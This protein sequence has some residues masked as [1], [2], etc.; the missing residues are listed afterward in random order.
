MDRR[1]GILRLATQNAQP[2]HHDAK[3]MIGAV[4]GSVR[5]G[6]LEKAVAL[7]QEDFLATFSLRNSVEFEEW[8]FFQEERLRSLLVNMLRR[9]VTHYADASAYTTA[10]TF[11]Q[12]WLA[13]DPL[14][15]ESHRVVIQLH[16]DHGE[17]TAA[18][19]QYQ[20]CV[21]LLESE[22]GIEPSSATK[23]LIESIQLDTEPCGV[24]GYAQSTRAASKQH[25]SSQNASKPTQQ[26]PHNISAE[27]TPFV[28]R[29]QDLQML[30]DLL[31]N[32]DCR[33]VTIFGPGGMGKTRLARQL[34]QTLLTE[35]SERYSDG[36]YFVSL[37]T[38]DSD[39]RLLLTMGETLGLS[40]ASRDNP[41]QKLGDYLADKSMLLVLDN[42]EQL[43]PTAPILSDLLE[44][45][46]GLSFQVT[47]RERLNLYEEWLFELDGLTT[48]EQDFETRFLSVDVDERVSEFSALQLFQ[49]RAQRLNPRFRIQPELAAVGRICRL[50]EGTPLAIELA[51]SWTRTMSCDRIE[52]EIRR[53]HDFLSTDTQNIPERQRSLRATFNYSWGL[54]TAAEQAALKVMSVFRGGFTAEEALQVANAD[55]GMVQA[56]HDKSL[57]RRAENERLELH[58]LIRQFTFEKLREDIAFLQSVVRRHCDYFAAFLNANASGLNG[59]QQMKVIADI[60]AEMDNVR[61][62]WQWA[63]AHQH[64]DA[65]ELAAP[66]LWDFTPI[67]GSSAE[68][69]SLFAAGV[70]ALQELLDN[71]QANRDD[72]GNIQGGDQSGDQSGD[73]GDNH[74]K[75]RNVMAFLMGG[76]GYFLALGRSLDSGR[77]LLEEGLALIRQST[78]RDTHKEATLLS[79]LTIVANDQGRYDDVQQFAATSLALFK[80]LGHERGMAT[81]HLD[82]GMASIYRGAYRQAD[83]HLQTSVELLTKLGERR[84]RAIAMRGLAQVAV[85]KGT[86]PRAHRLLAECLQISTEFDDATG[87]FF[88]YN[89]LGGLHMAEGNYDQAEEMLHRCIVLVEESGNQWYAPY[90]YLYQGELQRLK[91]N[92]GQAKRLLHACLAE[93]E[94]A[95]NRAGQMRAQVA[96]GQLAA[97]REEMEQAFHYY[98]EA[99]TFWQEEGNIAESAS[100]LR[101]L[102]YLCLQRS[103]QSD[104]AAD[105][106]RQAIT[107]AEQVELTPVLLDAQNGLAQATGSLMCGQ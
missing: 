33:L 32:A 65:L 100:T 26:P 81:S 74:E 72:Q 35:A 104:Q 25:D 11:A 19:R 2:P 69:E 97:E 63:V 61:A 5:I 66:C 4:A 16:A 94:G 95:D 102:G 89:E 38:A 13:L 10:L 28:G 15:E 14:Q 90:N 56:L 51:A 105:Y 43:I 60:H 78:E 8:H 68:T 85:K 20:A 39:T 53:S 21:Q 101:Y 46:A 24:D 18:R 99:L 31:L 96:L 6:E 57:L 76:Q 107:Q 41:K 93:F 47:S 86:Y 87:M 49:Q 36:I 77:A 3:H 88:A 30:Q 75:I 64:V 83:E 17:L 29:R 52:T 50:L 71:P 34:A 22:M 12:R 42:F 103:D 106:F 62:A 80:E 44:M 58:E 48:P 84:I 54:L 67:R 45:A 91:Q 9:L 1:S 27:T 79:R 82:L 40:F 70:A 37:A 7:Y 98:E 23:A 73:Q 59:P 55:R 92:Y